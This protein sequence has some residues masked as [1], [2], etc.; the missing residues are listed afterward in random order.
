[1]K[2]LIKISISWP[3]LFSMIHQLCT[4]CTHFLNP[5]SGTSE[6]HCMSWNV[7]ID[8]LHASGKNAIVRSSNVRTYTK[9]QRENVVMTT[10]NTQIEISSSLRFERNKLFNRNVF[11]LALS[12]SACKIRERKKQTLFKPDVIEITLF[13]W[14]IHTTAL[15]EMRRRVVMVYC[16]VAIWS[17]WIGTKM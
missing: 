12:K 5:W 16:A 10:K 14:H 13:L 17:A 6:V 7:L 9:M 2:I 4:I 8:R 3:K 1:M 15:T 11:F